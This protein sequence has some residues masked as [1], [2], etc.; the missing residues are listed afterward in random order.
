MPASA[1]MLKNCILCVSI[2]CCLPSLSVIAQFEDVSDLLGSLAP[3][4]TTYNGN[5]VS[6]ADL[7]RDGWDDLT[8]GRGN[9]EIAIYLNINGSF[10][11][12]PFTIP[13]LNA[14]QVQMVL[15]FDADND[16]FLDLLVTKDQAPIELWRNDGAYHFTN[17]AA[18]AGISQQSLNYSGAAVCD[19][20]HDGD[21]DFYVGKFYHPSI[22]LSPTFENEFYRNN[23]DGTFTE[24]TNEIGLQLGQRP[25]FQPLFLDYNNDGWEDLYLITDRVFVENALFRNNG[26]GSFTN[27]TPETGAGIMICSMTGTVA[28]YDNDGDLDVFISNSHVVGSRLMRNNGNETFSE[29]SEQLNLNVNQLGWGGLWIDYDNDTWQD[30]F[31]GLTSNG[32]FQFPGNRMYKNLQG[33]WFVDVSV[34]VGINNELIQTYV[35]AMA[36][37]DHDG[38]TDFVTNNNHLFSPK[39]FHNLGGS[40]HYLS[41]SLEGVTSN[42]QGIGSWITCYANGQS[43][44]KYKLAGENL[45]AQ[46]GDR[47]VFG[48]GDTQTVDSLVV[49]WNRGTRDVY[50]NVPA[51][52]HLHIIEGLSALFPIEVAPVGGNA[53]F[54]QNQA[55]ELTVGDFESYLW[56]TGETTPTITVNEPGTYGVQ[57]TTSTGHQFESALLE[58]EVYPEPYIDT[59]VSHQWCAD[60]ADAWAEVLIDGSNEPS[61]VWSDGSHGCCIENLLPGTVTY[62]FTDAYQCTYSGTIEIQSAEPL[63]VLAQT[64]PAS[65]AGYH[66]G[67]CEVV[68]FGGSPPYVIDWH[69]VDSQLLSADLYEVTVTDAHGCMHTIEYA[70]FE[71]E[72][73]EAEVTI[74]H[75]MN[76]SNGSA[77]LNIEGGTPP[78]SV[79]WTGA[80]G[81]GTEA[82][83]LPAGWYD[84][85]V[86]DAHACKWSANFEVLSETS[87]YTIPAAK[88][89]LYPNPARDY[90]HSSGCVDANAKS[91]ITLF[92]LH[93]A[94]VGETASWPVYVGHLPSGWYIASAR[95][96]DRYLEQPF[97]KLD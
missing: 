75:C 25:T 57:V 28:D 31:M 93:G 36:D 71:P 3:V 74:V 85:E 82:F 62:T 26:D 88:C 64:S 40:H 77:S 52:E 13:N 42:L 30:L 29:V 7:N 84:V 6:F 48:L 76:G 91:V 18:E 34:E 21:L 23:G 73:L 41:V 15:W 51:N 66:D 1:A 92:N 95:Q 58:V 63:I 46:N 24:V 4:Q 39:L 8:I 79:L 35:C 78:Y 97:F 56:S 19:F 45:I 47:M 20:D 27:V 65:C 81:F 43:Y 68:A 90:L 59:A 22:N 60:Q 87:V 54:C 5:G 9:G 67:Q 72:A 44:V 49:Q 94:R 70:I 53:A 12:A 17:I 10:Q 33:N 2:L 11:P 14:K 61:L 16:G 38:Y 50:Y 96:G 83:G 80:E 89:L 86:T 55:L 69:G 37:F 32:L